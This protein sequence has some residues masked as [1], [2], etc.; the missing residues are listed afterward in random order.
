MVTNDP[1]VAAQARMLRCNSNIGK[2]PNLNAAYGWNLEPDAI[3]AAVLNVKLK[4]L[5][6]RLVRRREI[7][8]RY[9]REFS[10]NTPLYLP[11]KQDGRV[12]QDYVIRTRTNQER[13]DLKTYLKGAGIKTLG[14]SLISHSLYQNLGLKEFKVPKTEEYISTQMRLPCNP[15]L[16]EWEVQAVIDAVKGF[17]KA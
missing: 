1:E 13:E 6:E 3:Q 16:E 17:Y 5:A 15:D 14:D 9:D 12:Y 7:A 8:E 4:Y 2:N 10:E 11:H